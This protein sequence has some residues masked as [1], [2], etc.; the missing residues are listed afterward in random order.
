MGILIPAELN[1]M[2]KDLICLWTE[3][4]PVQRF[5]RLDLTAECATNLRRRYKKLQQTNNIPS[6]YI[7]R[8][9]QF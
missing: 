7:K 9:V 4:G 6:L 5:T 3:E 1:F 8:L 2:N